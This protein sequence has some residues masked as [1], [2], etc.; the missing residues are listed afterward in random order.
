MEFEPLGAKGGGDDD[1]D[2][3]DET[4][5]THKL[6]WPKCQSRS[7]SHAHS[8][9]LYHSLG[10]SLIGDEIQNA[11]HPE[12]GVL[13]LHHPMFLSLQVQISM[14]TSTNSMTSLNFKLVIQEILSLS[15]VTISNA[16]EGH[17]HHPTS[18]APPPSFSFSIDR[19]F[20]APG[21]LDLR[22][23]FCCGP[24]MGPGWFN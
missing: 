5:L 12:P 23:S 18:K 9:P 6:L 8:L 10:S 4:T 17:H 2:I 21:S 3:N 24:I 15:V 1:H 7:H 20:A 11:N 14:R 19:R 13:L 22:G 16:A